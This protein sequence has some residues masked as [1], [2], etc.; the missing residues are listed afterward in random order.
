M[1]NQKE[2]GVGQCQTSEAVHLPATGGR[3][4]LSQKIIIGTKVVSTAAM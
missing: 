2:D 3:W 1:L 4:Q